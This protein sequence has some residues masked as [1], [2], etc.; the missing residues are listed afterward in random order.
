MLRKEL[1]SSKSECRR[2]DKK[3]K[4]FK[5]EAEQL[6]KDYQAI[7]KISEET[8]NQIIALQAKHQEDKELF[9]NNIQKL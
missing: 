6:N 7:S 4:V 3:I 2:Y 1:M 9:E 5:K 8:N